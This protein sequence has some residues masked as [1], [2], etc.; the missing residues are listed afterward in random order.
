MVCNTILTRD[1]IAFLEDTRSKLLNLIL[2]DRLL[3]SQFTG[4]NRITCL[5]QNFVEVLV[6]VKVVVVWRNVQILLQSLGIVL[7]YLLII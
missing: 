4:L 1:D 6:G 5:I 7:T 3:S 2:D